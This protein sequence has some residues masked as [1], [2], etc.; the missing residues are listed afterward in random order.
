LEEEKRLEDEI[1]SKLSGVDSV[2]AKA[3]HSLGLKEEVKD[4]ALELKEYYKEKS[5]K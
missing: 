4:P 2:L 3:I 5:E 1:R